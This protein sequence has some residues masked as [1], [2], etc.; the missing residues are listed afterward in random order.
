MI[1]RYRGDLQNALLFESNLLGSYFNFSPFKARNG[2][3]Y[4]IH[5][6]ILLN[7]TQGISFI[8][9][10]VNLTP[11]FPIFIHLLTLVSFKYISSSNNCCQILT[12]LWESK[13][14][15]Q[16]TLCHRRNSCLSCVLLRRKWWKLKQWVCWNNPRVCGSAGAVPARH[17]ACHT[18]GGSHLS[19]CTWHC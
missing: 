8:L 2:L 19:R 14:F 1:I 11:S 17:A 16:E 6:G 13:E 15:F 18:T 7:L 10:S 5:T 4:Q 12:K 3:D 9:P